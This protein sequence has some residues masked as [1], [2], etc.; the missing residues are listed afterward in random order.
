MDLRGLTVEVDIFDPEMNKLIHACACIEECFDHQ[1]ILAVSLITAA[2]QPLD[3]G[4]VEALDTAAACAGRVEVE[5]A[6]HLFHH[7]LGLVVA[8]MGLAPQAD[9]LDDHLSKV[10]M[11][12]RDRR[13]TA[14]LGRV[15]DLL[16][17]HGWVRIRERVG[18][19]SQ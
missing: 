19:I 2:D 6:A 10:R 9:G 12:L 18:E 13:M 8:Q 14:H 1:A 15:C 5:P 11:R 7:V 3:L 16:S 17:R 4:P